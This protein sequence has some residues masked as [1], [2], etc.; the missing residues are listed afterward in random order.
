MSRRLKL[1]SATQMTASPRPRARWSAPGSSGATRTTHARRPTLGAGRAEAAAAEARAAVD[2]WRR[3]HADLAR[4]RRAGEEVRRNAAEIARLRSERAAP[5]RESRS[6]RRRTSRRRRRRRP[7]AAAPGALRGGRR[8]DAPGRVRARPSHAA[9]YRPPQVGPEP[10]APRLAG[11]PTPFSPRDGAPF[12]TTRDEAHAARRAPLERKLLE[13]NV[14]RDL[15]EAESRKAPPH[16]RSYAE[17][18]RRTLRE[19]RRR[20]LDAAAARVKAALR[21]LN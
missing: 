14:Q 8:P 19:E 17:R 7:F 3:A 18:R 10:A 6:A 12:A 2:G 9:G 4:P 16:A 21:D 20:D 15:L 13:L 1:N 5:A 11:A